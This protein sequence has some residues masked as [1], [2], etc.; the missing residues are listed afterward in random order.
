MTA[1]ILSLGAGVQSSTLIYLSHA[2]YIPKYDKI[3]FA[4]T[5]DEPQAVYDHV[6]YLRTLAEIETV[7]IESGKSLSDH[8]YDPEMKF[9]NMPFYIV[10][11]KGNVS[12]MSRQCTRD[13]K[14]R[15]VDLC[16]RRWLAAHGLGHIDTIGRVYAA[17]GVKVNYH[18]GIS[19]DESKRM[20]EAAVNWKVHK[21]PLIELNMT[22]LDCLR[23]AAKHGYKRPPKSSCIYCPYHTDD[24]WKTL[25]ASELVQAVKLDNYIRS[26]EFKSKV[27]TLRGDLYIHSSCRPLQ[28]VIA[29]GFKPVKQLPVQLSFA[30]E[31]L[32]HSCKSD[33]GFS[34]FS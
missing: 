19:L 15:P 18:L 13:F 27:K 21:Y 8:I 26:S 11:S 24:Y 32:E 31:L 9:F 7:K 25:T 2:G 34:C 3:V 14:V 33:N 22:R 12:V 17:R 1:N 10:D 16:I 30:A 28:D 29:D 23:F 20:S 6:A 5:G 4:D